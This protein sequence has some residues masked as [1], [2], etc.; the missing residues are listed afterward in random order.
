MLSDLDVTVGG[1][2][3]GLR[4]VP[5]C[6]ALW[7]EDLALARTLPNMKV[8]APADKVERSLIAQFWRDTDRG[9]RLNRGGEQDASREV[10]NQPFWVRE[11]GASRYGW[12]VVCDRQYSGSW[13][14]RCAVAGAGVSLSGRC[15]TLK[16]FDTDLVLNRLDKNILRSKSTIHGASVKPLPVIAEAVC[17]FL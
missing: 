17:Q 5:W 12:C 10:M 15:A 3:G 2:G 8:L 7:A 4:M 13:A 14:R 6:D 11:C 16:P 9:V 1:V